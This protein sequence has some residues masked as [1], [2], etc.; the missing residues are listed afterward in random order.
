MI[1]ALIIFAILFLSHKLD[2]LLTTANLAC[3]T[4]KTRSTSFRTASWVLANNEFFGPCG[5]RILNKSRPFRINTIHEIVSQMVLPFVDI[6]VDFRSYSV[7]NVIKNRWSIKNI[8]IVHS[9]WS[10]KKCVSYPEVI[11]SYRLQ[12]NCWFFGSSWID[13]FPRGGKILPPSMHTVDTFNHPW[14]ST[15]FSNRTCR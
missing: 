12:H 15:L 9:T 6:E 13:S 10:S 5:S 1:H 2:G 3:R 8:K 11:W 7:N 4:P 14:K